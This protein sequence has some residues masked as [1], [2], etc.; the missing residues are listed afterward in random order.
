[1]TE[2]GGPGDACLR[3]VLV[4]GDGE[5]PPSAVTSPSTSGRGTTRFKRSTGRPCQ[6]RANPK[7]PAGDDETG[8]AVDVSRPRRTSTGTE[9][10]HRFP[11]RHRVSPPHALRTRRYETEAPATFSG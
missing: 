10:S 8:R 9:S 7:Q 3:R 5:V 6:I 11:R 2:R 4:T 1:M